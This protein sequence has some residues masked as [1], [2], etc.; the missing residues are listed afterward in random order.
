MKQQWKKIAL[1]Q[2]SIYNRTL[3]KQKEKE[4]T[5]NDLEETV[6]ATGG[7]WVPEINSPAD[8]YKYFPRKV[9]F[10]DELQERLMAKHKPQAQKKLVVEETI[11]TPTTNLVTTTLYVRPP[12]P[13]NQVPA[14]VVRLLQRNV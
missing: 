1:N 11:A 10:E 4:Q 8:I 14:I 9:T 7:L 2:E 5:E 6:F 13:G 3:E 12:T